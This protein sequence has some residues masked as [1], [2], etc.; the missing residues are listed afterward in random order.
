MIA[1]GKE[2]IDEVQQKNDFSRL[3]STHALSSGLK[4][5]FTSDTM[6]ALEIMRRAAGGHGFSSYAGI[7]LVSSEVSPTVTYEGENTI[8][9]L[10]TARFINKSLE[11]I[12]KKQSVV[13]ISQHLLEA[14]K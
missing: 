3:N 9:L 6:K 14:S 13:D 11:S 5:I 10:Q 7:A 8:L 12:S 4:A 1:L 2:V